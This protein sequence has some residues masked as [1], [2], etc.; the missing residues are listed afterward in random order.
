[1]VLG[2]AIGGWWCYQ[3]FVQ[4]ATARYGITQIHLS[5]TDVYDENLS[6]RIEYWFEQHKE[7]K[8]LITQPRSEL[9]RELME[10]FP[11]IR[12]V[13]WGTYLP[14]HLHCTVTG[15]RPTFMINRQY[16]A[17]NN[18]QLYTRRDFASYQEQMPV[19]NISKNWLNAS[20]FAS[21]HKF[22]SQLPAGLL[23]TYHM[24]Y[25]DPYT[26][27][28]VPVNFTELPHRCVCLV[29]ENSAARVRSIDELMEL[30]VDL[31]T[32]TQPKV[33]EPICFFDFRFE[34]RIISRVIPRSEFDQLQR[35]SE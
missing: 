2:V 11:L 7:D 20:A 29:D 21:V 31:K 17:G 27:A 24:Y 9:I 28:L 6:A 33:K 3:Q 30:C 22:F 8:S 19:L 10:A 35:V 23:R 1:M 4:W 18:G 26:I 25:H 15:V 5:Y 12:G 34:D 14:G 32:R 16:V 13:S